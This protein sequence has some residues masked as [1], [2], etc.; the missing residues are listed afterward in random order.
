MVAIQI[1]DVPEDVRDV[2]TRRARAKGQSLQA[3]LRDVVLREASFENNLAV[4]DSIAARRPG[5]AA[6]GDDVLDA[7]DRARE[8]RPGGAP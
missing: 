7:L 5:S 4:L 2:L 1:R 8:G 6:T 3:Y